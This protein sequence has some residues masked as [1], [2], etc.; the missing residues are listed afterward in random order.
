MD[1]SVPYLGLFYRLTKSASAVYRGD[2]KPLCLHLDPGS[3]VQLT[4]YPYDQGRLIDVLH[5]DRT[6]VMFME[7]VL[8]GEIV[9]FDVGGKKG[10]C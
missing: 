1:D 5:K 9:K 3:L 8:T 2:G 6:L 10:L 4:S 7:D